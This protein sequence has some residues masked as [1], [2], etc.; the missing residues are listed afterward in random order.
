MPNLDVTDWLDIQDTNVQ[1]EKRF[2]QLGIVEAVKDSTPFVDYISAQAKTQL[3]E[4]SSL[5]NIQL[6]TSL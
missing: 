2:S 6:W 4:T 5:R 1:N 3:Q